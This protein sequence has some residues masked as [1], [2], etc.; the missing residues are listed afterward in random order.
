MTPFF[1]IFFDNGFSSSHYGTENYIPNNK[2]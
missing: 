2:E 1:S